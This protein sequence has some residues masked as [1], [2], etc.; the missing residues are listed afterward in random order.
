MWQND[1]GLATSE[2]AIVYDSSVNH[3]FPNR[4]TFLFGKNS[5]SPAFKN[6]KVINNADV[7]FSI[8]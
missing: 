4:L 5:N 3:L 1:N 2:T 6:T 8:A 7:F